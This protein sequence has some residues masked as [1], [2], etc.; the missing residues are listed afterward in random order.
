VMGAAWLCL[1]LAEHYDYTLDRD[2]LE[3]RAFPLME[4]ALAFF[5]DYAFEGKDG[6]LHTGPSV[7]P[8]NTFVTED[9]Q[10]AAVCISPAMDAQILRELY[11]RYQKACAILGINSGKSKKIAAMMDRLPPARLTED[12]RIREWL[13]D[14][15]ETEPGHRHFSH[16]FALFP[17]SQITRETAELEAAARK[18]LE[19]RIAHGSG[20]T[21]WSCAWAISF[22][23]RLRDGDKALEFINILLSGKTTENMLNVHPPFQIDG[24]FGLS[25][26]VAEMLLQSHAGYIELLPALPKAWLKGRVKGL[27]ARG[28]ITV[29]MEWEEGRLKSAALSAASNQTVTVRYG[30]K[31]ER[32][33][34]KA[35]ERRT[36]DIKPT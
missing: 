7:S 30:N 8:E 33:D 14:Y 28:N 26:A 16:L 27:K 5:V 1:H 23:A 13:E 22:F 3:K 20:H 29:D 24:N 15:E 4:Q 31:T 21:G 34:L 9:G 18:T 32:L 12:G 17:G 11:G 19:H 10:R 6:F 36:V 35:G 25:A 2:F